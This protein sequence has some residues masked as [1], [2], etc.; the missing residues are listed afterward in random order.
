MLRITTGRDLH[1]YPEDY[2]VVALACPA[3]GITATSAGEV[4]ASVD[5]SC[6]S[7]AAITDSL[8]ITTP[9]ISRASRR[10]D[11]VSYDL[12]D[13]PHERGSFR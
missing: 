12:I 6:A 3:F 7:A 4:A 2:S 5:A 8:A 1:P 10:A 11:G 13:R 9:S